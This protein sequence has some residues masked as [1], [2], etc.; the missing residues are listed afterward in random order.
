M[1][2]KSNGDKRRLKISRIRIAV[3]SSKSDDSNNNNNNDNHHEQAITHHDATRIVMTV[4]P[5]SKL[6]HLNL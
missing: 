5:L 4:L 1:S 6:Q 2:N 3:Y